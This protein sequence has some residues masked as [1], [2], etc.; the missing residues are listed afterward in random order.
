[1][2]LRG[3]RELFCREYLK[4]LNGREAARRAGYSPKDVSTY[5]YVLLAESE[6]QERI[7][8]LAAERNAKLEIDA[9]DVLLELQR[10]AMMDPAGLIDENHVPHKLNDIP[11]DLRRTIA[12]IEIEELFEGRGEDRKHT[13][14][15]HKVKFWNK[16]QALEALGRHLALFKDSLTLNGKDGEPLDLKDT[17]VIARLA[18]IVEE[19]RRRK[20]TAEDLGDLV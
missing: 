1:M 20:S 14:R 16:N 5:P 6:V 18:G 10:L 11:I 9:R 19:L 8:E 17:N 12:S 15:L 4:D 2:E 13:G 3:K 7:S